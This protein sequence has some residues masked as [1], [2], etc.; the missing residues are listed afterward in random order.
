[1]EKTTYKVKLEGK[2]QLHEPNV[3]LEGIQINLWST[4]GGET[5]IND[6]VIVNVSGQLQVGMS[7]KAISGTAWEFA[8][9][10]KTSGKAVLEEEGQTG[11]SGI[12]NYSEIFKSVNP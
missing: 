9:T 1:M 7:C 12:P 8:V 3:K 2:S 11:S 4:D 6:N 10:N 5:W